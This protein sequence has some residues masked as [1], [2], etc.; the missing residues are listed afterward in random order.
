ME[1]YSLS[2][3][4]AASGNEGNSSWILIILFALIFGWGGNGFNRSGEFGQFA[5]AA[6]QSEILIGQQFQNLDNKIDRIGNG[7][8]DATFAIN[9]SI[10]DGNYAIQAALATMNCDNQR[11]VDSVR[12]DMANFA[13]QLNSNIDNKF[14]ALE[15]SQ[16]EQTIAAQ[17]NQINALNLAQQMAGVVKYPM[18]SAYAMLN[19]PFCACG[20]NYGSACGGCCR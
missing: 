4:A 11:N 20:N 2:D 12:Y 5:T 9:N 6:S 14:A 7:V 13:A 18:S 15:K 1:N 17:Q 16:L 8:A 10:K 3:I 19:N